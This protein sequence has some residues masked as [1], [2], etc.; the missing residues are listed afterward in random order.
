MWLDYTGYRVLVP[1]HTV[2]SAKPSSRVLPLQWPSEVW[3]GGTVAQATRFRLYD[4]WLAK[5]HSHLS[6]LL[7]FLCLA[8]ALGTCWIFPIVTGVRF[9]VVQLYIHSVKFPLKFYFRLN[10]KLRLLVGLLN[11]EGSLILTHSG[12]GLV[13][14]KTVIGINI[15]TSAS[16]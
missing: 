4:I 15:A 5:W 9:V 14:R 1:R 7:G 10:S 12:S 6:I 3:S 2:F 11:C 8:L 16:R 13:P